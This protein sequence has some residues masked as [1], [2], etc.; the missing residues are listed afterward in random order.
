MSIQFFPKFFIFRTTDLISLWLSL[1]YAWLISCLLHLLINELWSIYEHW[2]KY[3]GYYC[4]FPQLLPTFRRVTHLHSKHP[5]LLVP[6][7]LIPDV[8]KSMLV[9]CS[10]C[11]ESAVITLAHV[12]YIQFLK[13]STFFRRNLSF[14]VVMLGVISR[15]G[16]PC[17]HFSIILL[18]LM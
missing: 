1:K 8:A 13:R 17:S 7:V 9:V 10:C 16:P 3:T 18:G 15:P 6:T 5:H 12:C 2:V 11:A 4:K 14:S